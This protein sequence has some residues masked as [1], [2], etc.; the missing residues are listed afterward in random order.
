MPPVVFCCEG[1][2]AMPPEA[3][4]AQ[5]LDL[6]RWPEF[7]GYGPLPGIRSATFESRTDA[8][9]GT[10][11]RVRNTDGSSHVEEIVEW[12]PVRRLHLR[13]Q[14]FSSPLSRWATAFDETWEF[15]RDGD[16]THVRR[17]FAMHARSAWTRPVLWLI[18]WLLKSAIQHHVQQLLIAPPKPFETGPN[19]V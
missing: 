15:H 14:A 8:V 3:I 5:I 6:D 9:V 2:F 10:R 13:M 17:S 12:D 19:S 16:Q 11:I 18:S 7:R 1:R 4:A